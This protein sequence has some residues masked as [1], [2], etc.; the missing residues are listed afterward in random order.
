MD[1]KPGITLIE[2]LVYIGVST[3]VLLASTGLAYS[4]LATHAQT[5]AKADVTTSANQAFTILAH[6]IENAYSLDP[7][8]T[9]NVDL[10]QNPGTVTF[11][12]QNSQQNPTTIT[13]ANGALWLSEGTMLN[14][15]LTPKDVSVTHF[16]VKNFSS[17]NG[18]STNISLTLSLSKPV[19]YGIALFQDTFSTSIEVKD[20]AP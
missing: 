2:L 5:N 18:K 3:I 13:V 12:N 7:T 16:T 4:L 20:Y 6:E 8:S 9:I 11:H 17:A 15:R 19:G 14:Q 10:A 1:H